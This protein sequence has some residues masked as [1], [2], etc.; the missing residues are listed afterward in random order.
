MTKFH[1]PPSTHGT[2]LM[3]SGAASHKL[4]K[5]ENVLLH[6]LPEQEPWRHRG[7]KGKPSS[8]AASLLMCSFATTK[9]GRLRKAR[10]GVTSNLWIHWDDPSS[11]PLLR[12]S[13]AA[14]SL[15]PSLDASGWD[16]HRQ[17]EGRALAQ[18]KARATA[19]M[20][21]ENPTLSLSPSAGNTRTAPITA[22]QRPP[23]AALSGGWKWSED[24]WPSAWWGYKHH[25]C[26]AWQKL[27]AE[28]RERHGTR[29]CALGVAL[30]CS[31]KN[32][33]L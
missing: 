33:R 3:F 9:P 31:E 23:Q 21:A 22:D 6:W 30:L 28:R 29:L 19:Q 24:P 8:C 7:G 5:W 12:Q 2:T 11:F 18:G 16:R 20:A 15:D 27:S 4:E 25:P 14:G 26:L 1:S 10:L 32:F 13:F 17:A